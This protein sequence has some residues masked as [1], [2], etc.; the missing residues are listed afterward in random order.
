MKKKALKYTIFLLLIPIIITIMLSLVQDKEMETNN[1]YDGIDIP[2]YKDTRVDD[3]KR[4]STYA[5]IS[6]FGLLI[7]AGGTWIYVKKK[8]GF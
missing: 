7:I 4:S 3:I 5:Y 8:G 6:I 2:E 1:Q